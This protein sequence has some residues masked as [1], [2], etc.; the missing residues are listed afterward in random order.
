MLGSYPSSTF[1][2]EVCPSGNFLPS[3]VNMAESVVGL[4]QPKRTLNF[5]KPQNK[6]DRTV[7]YISLSLNS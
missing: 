5:P 1:T 7:R 3:R 6:L 2:Q 4:S